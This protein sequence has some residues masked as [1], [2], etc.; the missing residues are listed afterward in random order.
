MIQICN[1]TPDFNKEINQAWIVKE[2]QPGCNLPNI[3]LSPGISEVLTLIPEEEILKIKVLPSD[4]DINAKQKTSSAGSYTSHSYSIT[5]QP[6]NVTNFHLIQK[7]TNTK[8]L[9]FLFSNL[10]T[11]LIGVN[12][13][14]LLFLFDENSEAFQLNLSGDTYYPALRDNSLSFL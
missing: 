9:L 4:V 5:V 3:L 6:A 10:D 13:Q 7:F 1:N 2:G 14:G 12:Q 11:Y 8:V